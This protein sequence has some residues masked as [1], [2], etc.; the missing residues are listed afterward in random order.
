[1]EETIMARDE[2]VTTRSASMPTELNPFLIQVVATG[3]GSD[4][5]AACEAAH[6]GVTTN[7]I[8]EYDVVICEGY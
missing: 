7:V 2:A 5:R 6:G 1:M 4:L 3:M 8:I